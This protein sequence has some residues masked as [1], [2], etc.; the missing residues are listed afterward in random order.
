[1]IEYAYRVDVLIV[2][3]ILLLISTCY[4]LR[5]PH[6]LLFPGPRHLPFVGNIH[7]IDHEYPHK[8][9]AQ[10]TR[11]HGPLVYTYLFRQPALIIHTVQAAID[12]M[13]KKGAIHSSRPSF[14][15]LIELIGLN[16]NPALLP[17]GDRWR[18]HRKWL[19]AA[20][21]E[22]N[23]L[24]SYHPIRAR[25]VHRLLTGLVQSPDEFASLITSYVGAILT[26]ITYGHTAT[27]L[28]DDQ[29]IQM[30]AKSSADTIEACTFASTLVDFFPSLKHIPTWMPG[31]SFKR[32]ALR[33][34]QQVKIA[35]TTPY[36]WVKEQIACGSA[37]PS[38]VSSILDKMTRDGELSEDNER[39]L[40]GAAASIYNAGTDTS[41]TSIQTFVLAMVLYPEVFKKAQMEIDK[42]VGNS[43][44]PDLADR[45]S[46]PYLDQ[47]LL[48]VYRWNPPV[49]LGIPHLST[50]DD[51][52]LGCHIPGGTMT[53]SNIWYVHMTRD[54]E[55]YSDPEAFRPE[56][57]DELDAE[58]MELYNPGKIVFG[59]GRRICPG[60]YLA[61]S[62]IWLAMATILASFNI[63]KA[64][65]DK[66]N[67]ITPTPA[68]LP[69]LVNHP[70]LFRCHISPRSQEM[71]TLI[72]DQGMTIA[73]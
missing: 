52:Y 8:T 60:R 11:S 67:V 32:N 14:V 61:D 53:M 69:G 12:L 26:E 10:W 70:K 36:T 2:L 5:P 44:L 39:N 58:T 27:S 41:V 51:V 22:K 25:E 72:L 57:F 31:S 66:G 42:V 48:E 35:E 40:S 59:F 17:Y 73:V 19:Q 50:R 4:L 65:D 30:A 43:R 63:A 24:E 20:L 9:F 55:I 1:M 3:L 6:H 56:R 33:I 64:K 49:P 21:L 71:R 47:V 13:E 38:F 7:Q 29:F 34:R 18:R 28:E 15:F 23:I 62:S 16:N 37:R 45:G 54:P 46:L 68:F